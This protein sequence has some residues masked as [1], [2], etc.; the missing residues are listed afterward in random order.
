MSDIRTTVS[1]NQNLNTTVSSTNNFR[2]SVVGLSPSIIGLGNVDNTSDLDKPISIATQ[3]ALDLKANIESPTFTGTVSGITSAMVGLGNVDNTSDDNKPVSSATSAALGLKANIANPIFTGS[4]TLPRDPTAALEAAT[5]E[6]VDNLASGIIAKP[7]VL[8]ATSAN[9]DATYNNGVDGVGATLTSNVNGA[10]TASDVTGNI[11]I[12][13]GVLVKNQTAKAQNGRYFVSDVGS[14]S[15]PFVLT[16]CGLC[17]QADEIPGAYI[18]VQ[19]G[20]FKG[21]G[22]V[23][24][25]AD[26]TTFVVGVDAIDVFQFSGAGTGTGTYTASNGVVLNG[27]EFSADATIARLDSPT[28]TGVPSAPT[29]AADTNSTQIATTAYAKKEADDA[30]AAAV[31]RANH[32][33]TQDVSSITGL[34]TL[35]TQ[36]GTF[37]GSSSGTNTGDQT[38]TLTGEVTGSGTS[39]FTTTITN[40]SVTYAKIQNVSTASQLLGRGSSAGSGDVQEISIGSGLTLT[41]TVLSIKSNDTQNIIAVSLFA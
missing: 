18:F 36:N 22:Y 37:S 7:S 8:F 16:R 29:A 20:T 5:K 33:G 38:I 35:A 41:G 9:I 2:S 6:Y 34:G 19:D 26:P 30:Q 15:T 13:A 12:G 11:G 32:T 3:D 10:I 25:V 40:D 17:D 14:P 4:V 31:Q 21:S 24:I 1:Q 39:S 28:F 23:L 27:N